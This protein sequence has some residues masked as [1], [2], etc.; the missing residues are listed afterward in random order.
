MVNKIAI[1]A[2]LVLC[3][4][5]QT[6]AAVNCTATGAGRYAD[7][8]DTTCQNYTL[9]VLNSTSGTYI[10]Y[11]YVCPTTSVFN[12]T[13]S[14]CTASS[15]YVCNVTNTTSSV[16]TEDGYIAD[17]D[18]TNCTTYIECV[19]IDGSYIETTYTCP[20]DTYFDPNTTLCEADY[21]CTSTT[22]F[23]CTSAG[24]FA[25][26]TDTTCQTYYLCV[27][28]SN[29]T[30]YEYNYT[31]PSTSVFSPTERLCTTSYTCT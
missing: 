17:P 19:E 7:T 21:N 1:G 9:C 14:Q 26:T 27:L 25:D 12:P 22:S 13:T 20:D 11:N 3:L 6:Y 10:S 18:S 2:F 29:G 23:N 8:D 28:A 16:C 24:R 31:C 30:F 4:A 5:W 15:N